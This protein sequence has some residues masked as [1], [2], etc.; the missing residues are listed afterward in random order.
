V[1]DQDE[2][3]YF[4]SLL[5][6]VS[7][8][9]CAQEA[10]RQIATLLE[11]LFD[12]CC[13]IW[14]SPVQEQRGPRCLH[15]QGNFSRFEWSAQ[16]SLTASGEDLVK[17]SMGR[18]RLSLGPAGC[19]LV[20][21]KIHPLTPA[22]E[23]HLTR[24][25]Q[26][27]IGPLQTLLQH[28]RLQGRIEELERR[29]KHL[30]AE[31]NW[32][33]RCLALLQSSSE[34]L[35]PSSVCSRLTP[36][37][38]EA[39]PGEGLI[40]GHRHGDDWEIEVQA[41]PPWTGEGNWSE[42]W[43]TA[44]AYSRVVHFGDCRG[45]RFER[46]IPGALAITVAPLGLN[47]GVLCLYSSQPS[48]PSQGLEGLRNFEIGAL[49]LGYLLKISQLHNQ[50]SQA[51]H[52]LKDSEMQ[53]SQAVKLAAIAQIAAGVAHEINNPLASIRLTLEMTQRQKALSPTMEKSLDS[54]LLA[55]K[56][57]QDVARELLSFSRE[58]QKE[59]RLRVDLLE[60][61]R[62]ALNISQEWAQSR[63]IKLLS[64]LSPDP[65]WVEANPGQLQE[66]LLHV[67]ENA[68]WASQQSQGRQV[69]V[70]GQAS[71]NRAE[72]VITDCGPGVPPELAEKIFEP[73]FTTRPMGEATGL[74]LA[75]SRRLA[76]SFG[77]DLSL[78]QSSST[79]SSFVLSLPS[80]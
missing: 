5:S 64:Q 29:Q 10:A 69:L 61:T 16:I 38:L 45:S 56:R 46:A 35:D 40:V 30:E 12:C 28:E 26:L 48:G 39:F 14:L 19:V 78:R 20:E 70:A 50:L 11:R 74:G 63:S 6:L 42:L 43:G 31:S 13:E 32:L 37:I 75:L 59:F 1:N 8:A 9:D 49:V 55:V 2:R 53:R 17:H 65:L 41:G 76:Q 25:C 80:A 18:Y 79:G 23:R 15:P 60:V 34:L 36:L 7:T 24:C 51:Y 62:R 67:L 54:A 44:Y 73:F 72:I 66:I 33:N 3:F 52:A 22:Q 47:T 4:S 71:R 57:C 58:S 27:A 21:T 77:G 68:L